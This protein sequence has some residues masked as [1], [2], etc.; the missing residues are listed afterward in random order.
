MGGP[1]T[2]GRR[3]LTSWKM[4]AV[5]AG[6]MVVSACAGG[7]ATV[8][9]TNTPAPPTPAP[10]TDV[11]GSAVTPNASA[12]ATPSPTAPP[13]AAQPR[14]TAAP[15]A[16][17]PAAIRR[18]AFLGADG[19]IYVINANGSQRTRITKPRGDDTEPPALYT[20][21]TWSPDG[22]SLAYSR[23]VNSDVGPE[24]SLLVTSLDG[25]AMREVFRNPLDT[26]G[27]VGQGAPHYI[28]W[29]PDGGSLAFLAATNDI[30]L[31]VDVP[32]QN[33]GAETVS[34]G[35]P[36]YYAWA[37]DSRSLL[38]HG[39]QDLFLYHVDRGGIPGFLN[40][41]SSLAFR[42]PDWSPD[43]RLLAFV[44]EAEGSR[45]LMIARA[46]GSRLRS[47][48]PAP[49]QS[50]FAWSPRGDLIALGSS[51]TPAGGLYDGVR[52]I[53]ATTGRSR[54]LVDGPVLA[55]FWS[56]SG[57]RLA[58][59]GLD[60]SA[61]HLSL[62]VVD[63][64]SGESRTV[65]EFLPSQDLQFLFTFFDQYKASHLLWSPD[66]TQLA[67]SG[68]LVEGGQAVGA[69]DQVFVAD[70]TGRDAPRAIARGA[71]AFWPPPAPSGE[72]PLKTP[73][74]LNIGG[75]HIGL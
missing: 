68:R 66:G 23:A 61:R 43:G 60:S 55:F 69:E 56:P 41:P 74:Q 15:D 1:L 47:L 46:D 12:P 7:A 34:I 72:P 10:A 67:F 24:L 9:P 22:Q 64:A 30:T 48:S 52:L 33:R 36:L 29:S 54:A 6:L 73:V 75:P 38:I 27:L 18:L 25:G 50:S 13:P 5:A 40:L 42:V 45:T 65:A 2:S 49:N 51:S 28:F 62:D 26:F 19:Q 11:S 17:P 4:L 59:V 32:G 8:V 57:D 70:A 14:A 37:P 20:W 31:Y 71:L 58:V 35:A 3:T 53:D 21:P 39:G 63:T 44:G 16:S